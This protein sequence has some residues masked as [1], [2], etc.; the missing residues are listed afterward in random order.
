[1]STPKQYVL[2]FAS[3]SENRKESFSSDAEAGAIFAFAELERKTGGLT[4]RQEKTAFITKVGYPL[5]LI[6]RGDTTYVF[7]GLNKSSFLWSYYEASQT[8]IVIEDFVANFKIREQYIK[9]LLNYQKS[10][11]QALNRKELSCGGL[12]ANSEFLGE[13]DGYRKEATEIVWQ[14]SGLGLLSPA[15]S[16]TDAIGVVNQIETLQASFREKTE[17]LTAAYAVN[18]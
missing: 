11:Q 7:D 10:F 12:I 15:L 5:W 17:K 3:Q 1:M 18:F 16:E 2:P 8:E 6:V 14:P 9:F 4:N 13:L